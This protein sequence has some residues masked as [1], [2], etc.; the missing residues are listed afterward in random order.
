MPKIVDHESRRAEIAAAVRRLVL[1]EGVA[2]ATVRK[3]ADEAGWSPGA[4]RHYFPDQA[5]L[6]RLVIAQAYADVPQR[7]ESHLRSWYDDPSGRDPLGHAQRMLEELLPLDDERRVEAEVWL[8]TM[9]AARHDPALAEARAMAWAGI[10]QMSRIA[11]AWVRGRELDPHLGRLLE[12]PLAE[13]VDERAAATVH[14]L[15]DGL[16]MQCYAYAEQ[17]EL[18]DLRVTLRSH[19]DEVARGA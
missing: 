10:R 13:P 7:L 1:R 17:V 12:E 11:V 6:L 19:L 15:L 5:A 8:A 2:S 9:D 3:V 18:D 4:V 14:A 16:A